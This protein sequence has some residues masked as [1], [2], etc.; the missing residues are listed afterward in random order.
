MCSLWVR[1]GAR[2]LA[3]DQTSRKTYNASAISRRQ[4]LR[5]A[6]DALPP[7]TRRQTTSLL[8][9]Q[10]TAATR[11]RAPFLAVDAEVDELLAEAIS[12][13]ELLEE[14]QVLP[15]RRDGGQRGGQR[16]RSRG[17]GRAAEAEGEAEAEEVDRELEEAV[18][19]LTS[20]ELAAAQESL[21][22][23]EEAV[24]VGGGAAVSG[25]V[26]VAARSAR[27]AASSAR[28]GARVGARG[29]A[30][31]VGSELRHTVA[32]A[33][34]P[35]EEEEKVEGAALEVAVAEP[36]AGARV[37]HSAAAANATVAKAVDAKPAAQVARGSV[38]SASAGRAPFNV[39]LVTQTDVHRLHYL[40]EGAR[41]WKGAVAGHSADTAVY[42]LAAPCHSLHQLSGTRGCGPGLGSLHLYTVAPLH[43][44]AHSRPPSSRRHRP[45]APCTSQVG[46]LLLPGG[47]TLAEVLAEVGVSPEPQASARRPACPACP[48]FP[49][50]P[51]QAPF[52][53]SACTPCAHGQK[54]HRPTTCVPGLLAC[55]RAGLTGLG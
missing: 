20:E 54:T 7:E 17:S 25:G 26:P 6:E 29:G 41:R 39:S 46:A 42:G 49:G 34:L 36:F 18:Q 23:P 14:A 55:A 53:P 24:A 43:L 19:A 51:L 35:E 52:A 38:A 32:D 13:P 31:G 10:A 9:G 28:R 30:V 21:A 1:A 3:N 16:G 47:R 5:L 27:F 37:T 45:P 33:A 40:F 11:A 44:A 2:T 22:I 15:Q 48:A 4:V 12:Q 50:C 8:G